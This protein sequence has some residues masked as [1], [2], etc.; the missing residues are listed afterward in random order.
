V[1]ANKAIADKATK[2][3]R[4]AAE[5][6]ARLAKA[7]AVKETSVGKTLGSSL[8]LPAVSAATFQ[9]QFFSLCANLRGASTALMCGRA[10]L[11]TR[12]D[13]VDP[14]GMAAWRRAFKALPP[15]RQMM[16]ATIICLYRGEADKLWLARL[17]STCH[18]ADAIAALREAGA[19]RDWG[20]ASCAL[21][22]MVSGFA[23][24]SAR[25][26]VPKTERCGLD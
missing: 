19:L 4:E 13:G 23:T 1:L 24:V 20:P 21:P 5:I 7:P 2:L 26:S 16:V 14:K 15:V 22:R 18:A 8:P 10:G 6:S 12:T 11:D 25:P 3:D 17:A 9:Q